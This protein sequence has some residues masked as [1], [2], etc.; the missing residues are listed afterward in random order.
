MS[1]ILTPKFRVSYPNV[2]EPKYNELSKRNEFS[3]VALFPKGADLSILR[4]AAA[5]ALKEKFPTREK[6]PESCLDILSPTCV[7]TGQNGN[8]F[9]D[10]ADREQT[11]DDGRKMLP[12][13]YEKG[14]FYLNLRSTQRPGLVDMNVV[15][16][17]DP[18]Q[19]YPGCWA[20]ADL[21]VY[22]YEKGKNKGVAFGLSNIQK[23]ADGDAF[24]GR[25]KPEDAFAAIGGGDASNT[26]DIFGGA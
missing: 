21:S 3:I 18:T 10:Q 15:E 1:G 25:A 9:R 4:Q 12:A 5:K 19:F 11:M 13:G 7:G 23:V 16:I 24:S 22:A 2:F 17:I 6:F 26:T 14:A 20:R 8:P